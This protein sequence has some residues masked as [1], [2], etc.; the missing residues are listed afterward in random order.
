MP[1]PLFDTFA[2]ELQKKAP[3]NQIAAIELLGHIA[4]S[5]RN[6]EELP[7]HVTD[8]LAS[9]LEAAATE[10]DGM[11]AMRA[12]AKALHLV[13]PQRRRSADWHDVG[14]GVQRLLEGGWIARHVPDDGEGW[15]MEYIADDA[16]PKMSLTRAAEDIAGFFEIDAA[17]ARRYYEEYK[18]AKDAHDSIE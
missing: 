3:L 8:Y 2:F 11:S 16:A 13:M 14:I 1:K 15:R 6:G 7:P 5:M 9:A 18:K 17:T 12:L 4:S 10:H